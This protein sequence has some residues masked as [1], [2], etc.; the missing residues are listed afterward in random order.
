MRLMLEEHSHE[1][2]YCFHGVCGHFPLNRWRY[3]VIFGEYSIFLARIA[4]IILTIMK[5]GE[6]MLH[7]NGI[8][9]V[10]RKILEELSLEARLPIAELGRRIKL[11]PSATAERV[12]RLESLQLIRG[13]RADIN[14]S[15]LGFSI[16]AFVRLT[17][18]GNRYRPFLKFIPTLDAVQECHHLTGGDA[19]LLKVVLSSV[20]QL[21][22][23]IEKLLPYGSPTTSMVL[24]TPL[25]RKRISFLNPGERRKPYARPLRLQ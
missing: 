11:S 21:E 6:T 7:H 4:V 9:L 19:F 20:A 24:S 17:C 13:Y 22:D 3:C 10:D 15:A 16:T 25:E 23:L 12:R 5:I 8:D 14:L 2:G 18:D 1:M